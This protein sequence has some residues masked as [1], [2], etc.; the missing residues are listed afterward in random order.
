MSLLNQSLVWKGTISCLNK[1]QKGAKTKTILT[2]TTKLSVDLPE[3]KRVCTNTSFQ[4]FRNS[5]CHRKD[6]LEL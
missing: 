2:N 1:K 5:F 6:C 3:S 4:V